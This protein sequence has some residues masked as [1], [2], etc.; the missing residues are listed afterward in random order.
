M[1]STILDNIKARLETIPD[2]TVGYDVRQVEKKKSPIAVIG[3]PSESPIGDNWKHSSKYKVKLDVVI[4]L[5]HTSLPD[6]LSLIESAESAL[7]LTENLPETMEWDYAGWSR[8]EP[9]T[10]S[11]TYGAQLNIAV[12]YVKAAA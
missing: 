7:K 6:L 5:V 8:S 9:P 4:E 1:L 11:N 12:V 10:G 3:L 2:I